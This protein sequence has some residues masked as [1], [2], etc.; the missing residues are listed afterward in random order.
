MSQQVTREQQTIC[1]PWP[2]ARPVA[3]LGRRASS[4]VSRKHASK[5]AGQEPSPPGGKQARKPERTQAQKHESKSLDRVLACG[6]G[7]T[8]RKR[9]R[10]E[11]VQVGLKAAM[12]SSGVHD[13]R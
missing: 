12:R 13:Q 4:T 1:I 8:R 9:L 10:P 6:L 11:L 5:Q 7:V 3:S 2:L